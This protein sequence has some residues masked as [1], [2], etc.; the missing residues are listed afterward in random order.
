MALLSHHRDRKLALAVQNVPASTPGGV[1]A[2]RPTGC[3]PCRGSLLRDLPGLSGDP[4]SPL[5][6][7]GKA[8]R[9]A[10]S[11]SVPWECLADLPS[12]TTRSLCK[13]SSSCLKLGGAGN[14]AALGAAP[15]PFLLPS[16]LRWRKKQEDPNGEVTPVSEHFGK[17]L[18][19]P[20]S[21]CLAFGAALC[22]SSH[23]F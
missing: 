1:A 8:H 2:W 10:G 15:C 18:R 7:G 9:G 14:P 11:F 3:I 13:P 17:L 12:M 21:C 20:L 19:H 5:A 16:E 22:S 6:S 23:R 4:S